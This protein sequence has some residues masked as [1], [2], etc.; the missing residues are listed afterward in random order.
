MGGIRFA[1]SRTKEMDDRLVELE[2]LHKVL[3]EGI[4]AYDQMAADLIGAK[5]RLSRI[6]ASKDKKSTLLEMVEK[7]ELNRSL[8][9]LLDENIAAAQN[10]NQE[11]A[12]LF[13]EKVRAAV[14]KYMTI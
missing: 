13:M 1:V 5:D 14:L 9:A 2:A 12:A 8:L 11:Q 3:T 7:N 4:E 10:A 6:L